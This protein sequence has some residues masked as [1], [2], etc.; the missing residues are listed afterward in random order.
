M[1]MNGEIE[2]GLLKVV[3]PKNLGPNS[4]FPFQTT[5]P[6]YPEW[7]V[8]VLRHVPEEVTREV[9]KAL[10]QI[11]KTHPAAVAGKYA[12]WIPPLSYSSL[13]AM[14]RSLGWIKEPT[15]EPAPHSTEFVSLGQCMKSDNFYD[16]IVCPD[17][18]V[19]VS[20]EAMDVGC[21]SVNTT[22]CPDGYSCVC[23]PCK[24]VPTREY[25]IGI[26]S[27]EQGQEELSSS[28][29]LLMLSNHTGTLRL[30]EKK[31]GVCSTS[32]IGNQVT[33]VVTDNWFGMR[34]RLNVKPAA[35]LRV[36][37]R[38]ASTRDD[39]W[40]DAEAVYE[41][42]TNASIGVFTATF[43]STKAGS[44]LTQVVV[45]ELQLQSSPVLVETEAN[46][47]REV[48][49]A[50]AVTAILGA[51]I[52]MIL[53]ATSVKL[54]YDYV[55]KRKPV[56]FQAAFDRMRENGDIS[57]ASAM[58]IKTPREIRRHDLELIEK[59]GHGDFG[60]VWKATLDESA[61]RDNPS[62][63]VAAKTVSNPKVRTAGSD[64]LISEAAIMMQVTAHPNLVAIIGVIT[65]GDPYVLVLQYCEEGS[66]L[67]YLKQEFAR[68]NAV[69]HSV[70]M[71]MAFEVASGMDHLGSLKLIHRDLAAR[72]V[73]L[74]TGRSTL[75]RNTM[76]SGGGST[77]EYG[78]SGTS[79]IC[80]V[81]D[82]GLSRGASNRAAD[83]AES[84]Y[85]SSNGVFPVR[86]SAPESME[87]LRFTSASDIWSYG[88]F[89]VELLSDGETP[90]PGMPNPDVIKMVM[91]GDRHSQPLRCPDD[92]YATLLQCWN[93]D[94]SLR[95]PFSTLAVSLHGYAAPQVAKRVPNP[96]GV[97]DVPIA[98]ENPKLDP[99]AVNDTAMRD[100][101][102]TDDGR[103]RSDSN[104]NL[105]KLT[106]THDFSHDS[107]NGE[108]QNATE[109]SEGEGFIFPVYADFSLGD[110][111]NAPV[112]VHQTLV[113]HSSKSGAFQ[114]E[115][116]V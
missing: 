57:I 13:N 94:P 23:N 46:P 95:P 73:L 78:I 40:I 115:T 47:D 41:S 1:Q 31:L 42:R 32:K 63:T 76:V 99:M 54:W 56:D 9:A 69:A 34:D 55:Q 68:G 85:R 89:I 49:S 10:L 64:D 92:L 53:L 110:N 27:V 104:P 19:K 16:A 77:S 79:V 109:N 91:Q 59:I 74:A 75:R 107:G 71:I 116:F 28:A 65:T 44:Y 20:K 8:A 103:G 72:N 80:K 7:P 26:I 61:S 96:A 29:R 39:V 5:T 50:T 84:Y 35:N 98:E 105:Y 51:A 18:Y 82:F 70:K 112:P 15:E 25:S 93:A 43:T 11:D 14:Q 33:I 108:A 60:D 102:P 87:T 67:K 12:E 30:C 101:Q 66:T 52:G 58:K 21:S 97:W 38:H 90:Y 88:V 114:S 2:P 45:N 3:S 48:G 111:V 4:E 24:K 22:P 17:T 6:L 83:D 106:A 62:F 81:A 100:E 36:N 37:F 113:K 86:W